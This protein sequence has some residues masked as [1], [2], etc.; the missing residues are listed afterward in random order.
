MQ[1]FKMGVDGIIVGGCPERSCH[2]LYGNFVADKRIE[3]ARA[4]M[5]QLG[6]EPSRLRFEYIGAPMQAKLVETI[7]QMDAKLRELGP[8]P[9]A[10]ATIS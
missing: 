8:N 5:G 4:L 1:M 2:H 3:L 6:L 7:H 9:A 10:R